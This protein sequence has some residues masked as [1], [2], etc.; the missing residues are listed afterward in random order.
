M[1]SS[2]KPAR[3]S[4][5][6]LVLACAIPAFARAAAAPA[7]RGRRTAGPQGAF[8]L[9]V[10]AHPL[11]LILARPEATSVTL[12]L[13]TYQDLEVVVDYGLS[14]PPFTGQTP[15][16]TVRAGVPVEIVLAGLR[17]NTAYRYQLRSRAPGAATFTALPENTFQTA[18]APGAAFTFTLTADVHLDEHTAASVYLQSLAN[19]RADRPDFHL[20]LGNLFMTDKHATRA[21]AARQYLAQRYYLGQI[22][23]SIPVL[24][25]LGTHDGESGKDR[26]GDDSLAAWAHPMR[27][28][29]FPNPVPD[30]FYSGNST[31][32]PSAGPS[33]NYYAWEWGDALFVVLD[34][35]SYTLP[36]RGRNDGWG[37]TL[38]E[39]QYRWLARTL[40]SS[41]AAYKFVFIHNLLSGDQASRGGVEIAGFNEWGG[42]NSDGTE[43]FAQHR[44]GW[45]LPVHQLLV[46]NHVNA[47]FRAHDNFYA[48]QELDGITYLMVPQPSFAGDDRVRDLQNYGYKAGTFLGN[49]GHVRVGVS[50]EKVT[51]D[52]VKSTPD[53]KVADSSVIA[54]RPAPAGAGTKA[55]GS[56]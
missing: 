54:N 19:I 11:D 53:R 12:S 51:I 18:R 44:P 48:R 14:A 1:C 26:T 3:L 34:P 30:R 23:P 42:K 17:P 56:R 24:L 2:Q 13:L 16:Q 22:G 9:D 52:Y 50:T 28:R 27:T 7:N 43:G 47:V 36:T 31:A 8:K 45:E 5:A 21:E 46:R 15:A 6:V 38:G 35:F 41:R 55:N 39:A 4:L 37:W 29:Y 25:A 20:D 40:G 33:Q 49:A 32:A 10:P